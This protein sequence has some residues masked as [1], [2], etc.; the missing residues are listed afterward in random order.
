MFKKPKGRLD[1]TVRCLNLRYK[2]T[3]KKREIAIYEPH[4]H[5]KAKICN[6]YTKKNKNQA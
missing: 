6:I 2:Y 1:Y 4:G 3:V 5:H